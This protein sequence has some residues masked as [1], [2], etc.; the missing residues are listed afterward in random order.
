M[1][2]QELFALTLRSVHALVDHL[3]EKTGLTAEAA[4]TYIF[5]QANAFMNEHLRA[6]MRL[7]KDKF[8]CT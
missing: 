6:R 5:Q 3:L 8:R 2:G 7:P 4:D 1:D